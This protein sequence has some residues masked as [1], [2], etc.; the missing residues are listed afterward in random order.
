MREPICPGNGPLTVP[1]PAMPRTYKPRTG[2]RN[3]STRPQALPAKYEPGFLAKLDQ[4]TE[5]A[6]LLRERFQGIAHDLGG[7]DD[8]SG[9][10]AS[11]LERFVFLEATLSRLECDLAGSEDAKTASEVMCR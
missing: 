10:K 11:L 2:R 5:L 3:A 7:P 4:R 6:R 8:L 1:L 9:I